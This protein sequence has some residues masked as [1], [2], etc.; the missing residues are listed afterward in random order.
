[1]SKFIFSD[2]QFFFSLGQMFRVLLAARATSFFFICCVYK[3][4][5]VIP[6]I[7]EPI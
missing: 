4:K 5:M 1:M 7:V 3:E 2:D 6:K